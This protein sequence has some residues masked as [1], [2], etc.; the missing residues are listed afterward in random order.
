MM[1]FTWI[2]VYIILLLCLMII[3]SNRK[4]LLRLLYNRRVDNEA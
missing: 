3:E 2:M 1:S 4:G